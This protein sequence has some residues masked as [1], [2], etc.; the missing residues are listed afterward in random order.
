MLPTRTKSLRL[1][2]NAAQNMNFVVELSD[3]RH[4][5]CIAVFRNTNFACSWS[6]GRK[7]FPIIGLLS[8]LHLIELVLSGMP[9]RSLGGY[10][11]ALTAASPRRT[12]RGRSHQ[13]ESALPLRK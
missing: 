8:V 11:I 1:L 2:L 6:D 9:D 7:G 12:R 4:T 13:C 10:A 5:K 3:A